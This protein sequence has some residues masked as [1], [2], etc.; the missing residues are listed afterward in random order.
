M[1][2]IDEIDWLNMYNN[3][4]Q[5]L[6]ELYANKEF[7]RFKQLEEF[8]NCESSSDSDYLINAA[9]HGNLDGL[10]FFHKYFRDIFDLNINTVLVTCAS[11]GHDQCVEYLVKYGANPSILHKTTQYN[12]YPKVKFALWENDK[13]YAHQSIKNSYHHLRKKFPDAL[14]PHLQWETIVITISQLMPDTSYKKLL[15][16]EFKRD[17]SNFLRIY[18]T[19]EQSN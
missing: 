3:K 10:K 17:L 8:Y 2:H 16:D 15:V 11:F 6:R 19:G 18:P 12:L 9:K 14:G 4:E 1:S 7:K 5:L 13:E